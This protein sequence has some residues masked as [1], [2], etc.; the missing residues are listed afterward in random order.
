MILIEAIQHAGVN[1]RVKS[2][3]FSEYAVGLFAIDG[4]REQPERM[5]FWF[6]NSVPVRML[7]AR[8]VR[9][10]MT[11]GHDDWRPAN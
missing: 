4:M 11:D 9:A 6:D 2:A 8:E 5:L 3:A 10:F 1:G 7:S